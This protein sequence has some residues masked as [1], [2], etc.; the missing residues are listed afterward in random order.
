MELNNA[1]TNVSLLLAGPPGSGKSH[2]AATAA[3]ALG[4][5]WVANFD[6]GASRVYEPFIRDGIDIQVH[7]YI[8][9]PGNPDACQRFHDAIDKMLLDYTLTCKVQVLPEEKPPVVHVL[10]S[11]TTMIESLIQLHFYKNPKA[12]GKRRGILNDTPV[13]PTLDD[14]NVII[15]TVK[16]L[17]R[18]F[19]SL[20]GLKIITAHDVAITNEKGNLLELLPSVPGK[21]KYARSFASIFTAAGYCERDTVNNKWM[22]RFGKKSLCKWTFFRGEDIVECPNDWTYIQEVLK[23]DTL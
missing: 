3:K 1:T 14:W 7:D 2:T 4:K 5:M 15:S 17:I 16:P 12:G 6:L 19:V 9:E 21:N 22:I 20:P 11:M 8:D 23:G 13:V 10:D 18:K